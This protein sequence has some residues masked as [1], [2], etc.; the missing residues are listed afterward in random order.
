MIVFGLYFLAL[1]YCLCLSCF[2]P[3]FTL[4]DLTAIPFLLLNWGQCSPGL[5]WGWYVTKDVVS[6]CLHIKFS[7][8]TILF[9]LSIKLPYSYKL[10]TPQCSLVVKL[11]RSLLTCLHFRPN[12]VS[13]AAP[14]W[15]AV[16]WV[17][18][19]LTVAAL[20]SYPRLQ[21]HSWPPVET[22]WLI[23]T[24]SDKC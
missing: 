24:G 7:V 10:H 19:G 17:Q 23:S 21:H 12:D 20:V 16:H 6:R 18:A 3:T 9:P 5:L 4:L 11:D 15:I 2:R 14:I 13:L 8:S 22:A 1:E